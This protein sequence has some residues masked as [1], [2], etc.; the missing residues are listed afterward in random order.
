MRSNNLSNLALML[1]LLVFSALTLGTA[2]AAE[3][4]VRDIRVEGLTR[5]SAGTIF[6]YLPVKV[7][8]ELPK[9]KTLLHITGQVVQS[10]DGLVFEAER[11]EPAK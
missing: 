4:V 7:E 6:N 1:A 9:P 11:M 3:F 8:G 5:I 10:E 2:L